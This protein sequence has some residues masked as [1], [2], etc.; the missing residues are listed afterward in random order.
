[1]GF[2]TWRLVSSRSRSVSRRSNASF[3]NESKTFLFF[4]IYA[5]GLPLLVCIVTAIADACREEKKVGDGFKTSL[6]FP[7]MGAV[8]CFV[9]EHF[10]DGTT[11]FA[12]SKF[13]YHD[14]FM[15]I[16][17]MFNLY[18]Y[19]SI[20]VGLC[21]G[22]ENQDSIRRMKGFASFLT[23][24]LKE[25]GK[26]KYF[27]DT[28][29]FQEKLAKYKKHAIVCLRLFIILGEVFSVQRKSIG[30]RPHIIN[31]DSFRC[32]LDPGGDI[33]SNHA[34][35]PE[36]CRSAGGV[37]HGFGHMFCSEFQINSKPLKFY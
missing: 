1:M 10:G 36:P 8:R 32:A 33:H 3:T 5:Q 2:K 15:V 19:G 23:N 7:N 30:F 18:F 29:D 9:G 13:L 22:W 4:G 16:I 24:L 12:S 28:E 34:Q 17:Q 31:A 11:Y 21:K 25:G 35:R 6:Y 14:M 26:T 27:R 20:C 37:P